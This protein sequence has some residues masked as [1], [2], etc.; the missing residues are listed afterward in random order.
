MLKSRKRLTTS[1]RRRRQQRWSPEQLEERA[2]LSAAGFDD[3]VLDANSYSSDTVVVQFETGY[4][5]PNSLPLQGIKVG[6]SLGTDGLYEVN[7][8]EGV[9]PEEAISALEAHPGV[10][11]AHPDFTVSLAAT[12][13]DPAFNSL[14]GMHNTGQTGGT[15]DADIDATEAWDIRTD[16]SEIVVAVIDTGIDYTHP[17][18]AANMWVN[19][20]EIAGDGIDNDD[21]GFVDDVHGY[22][23][24]NDD[25]DPMDDHNHGTHVAGTIGA[26]GDNGVGV[27]GVAWNVQLMGVKFLGANGSGSLANA[28][29]AIN[30]TTQMN[31]D[32][33]NNS[34][35]G[36]G[37]VQSLQDAI[38]SFTS[39]GGIFTAAA[40]NHGGNNDTGGFYPANYENVVAVAA[41]DHND[42][43]ANFSGFGVNT[44]EVAAPG[45]SIR[46][47]VPGGGYSNFSGTSM[48]TPMVSGVLAILQAEFPAETDAEILDRMYMSTDPILTDVTTH[49]RVNLFNALQAAPNDQDGPKVDSSAWSGPQEGE[50]DTV[51]V[52]FN[53]SIDLLTFTTSDVALTG[54]NGSI[55][56]DSVTSTNAENTVFEVSFAAQTDVGDYTMDIGPDVADIAGNLMDQDMDGTGGEAGDDVFTTSF[57]IENEQVVFEWEGN[58]RIRD[59]RRFRRRTRRG[60]TVVRM[61]VN[62]D[63]TIDDLDVQ[64][65]LNHTWTSDLAIYVFGPGGRSLLFNRRGGDGDNILATFD[66]EA[67]TAI[68]DGTAPF[69]GSFR[70]ESSL[71]GFDGSS[72]LGRWYVVIYDLAPRDV[73]NITN[74]KLIVTPQQGAS[75]QIDDAS[76]SAAITYQPAREMESLFTE[77]VVAPVR[78]ASLETSAVTAP[79]E[80]DDSD[81]RDDSESFEAA[82][83]EADNDLVFAFAEEELVLL[84]E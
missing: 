49:G 44:V 53:E 73:G 20:G 11:Y 22:D 15:P 62:E 4:T 10:A 80:A 19:E 42:T 18:L 67:G 75:T 61:R 48:A 84:D 14:W 36:G 74:V 55:V 9:T 35:G 54:P 27:A 72:T 6:S 63:V 34:W 8:S 13:N 33:S 31:A 21:N 41:S 26:V 47:T 82:P 32:I 50:V 25:G 2:L 57:S 16:A 51:T 46:S 17:D 60:T 5:N 70:P 28:I 78:V 83:V 39:N 3:L 64:L 56:V 65:T 23:F 37:F 76:G 77:D 58:Q 12:P 30:Y 81:W 52:T 66:D 59:A 79:V 45:V 29:K 7:L 43:K 71:S 24:V 68:A 40:G 38:N 1:L 69:D